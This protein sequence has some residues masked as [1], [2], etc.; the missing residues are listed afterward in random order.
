MYTSQ[1]GWFP[2]VTYE[3]TGL[4]RE[5]TCPGLMVVALGSFFL[6]SR[7]HNEFVALLIVY[8]EQCAID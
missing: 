4:A 7:K 3:M 5:T 8:C 6:H 1:A 2:L